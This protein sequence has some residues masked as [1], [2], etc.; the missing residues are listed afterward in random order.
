MFV[1]APLLGVRRK[2]WVPLGAREGSGPE[3]EGR[4]GGYAHCR[5][6]TNLTSRTNPSS[7]IRP[8]R[9]SLV[10]DGRRKT[11]EAAA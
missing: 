10:T 6:L 3:N 8:R 9:S 2:T 11:P 4:L 1:D 7:G 5:Q